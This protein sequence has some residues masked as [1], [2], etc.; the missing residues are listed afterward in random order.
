MPLRVSVDE[1]KV[2]ITGI[3]AGVVDVDEVIDRVCRGLEELDAG[4]QLKILADLRG[5]EP[6]WNPAEIREFAGFVGENRSLFAD[7]AVAVVVSQT[8]QY[9]IV[10]MFQAYTDDI[11]SVFDIFYDLDEAT[12]WLGMPAGTLAA[13]EH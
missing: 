7:R 4:K 11:I 1:E 10:R 13:A 8:V 9:G 5:Q 6:H 2:L 12:R 3:L